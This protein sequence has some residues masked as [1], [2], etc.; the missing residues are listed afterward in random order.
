MRAVQW[1]RKPLL[2][3][4]QACAQMCRTAWHTHPLGQAL[5]ITAGVGRVQV[6]GG[7]IQEVRP[8]DTVWFPPYVK[9]WHGAAPG[10]AMTHISV[11]EEED[12]NNVEWLEKVTEEQYTGN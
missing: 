6:Q 11:A 9:H 3:R 2:V 10:V 8:G 4:G 12:G 5:V 7:P 1:G